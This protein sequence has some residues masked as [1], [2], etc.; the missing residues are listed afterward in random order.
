MNKNKDKYSMKNI[1]ALFYC[2]LIASNISS[3]EKPR[4]LSKEE[5]KTLTTALNG[6]YEDNFFKAKPNEKIEALITLA[7][8]ALA[9]QNA[10]TEL[11]KSIAI[12]GQEKRNK[13]FVHSAIDDFIYNAE[14]VLANR[15]PKRPVIMSQAGQKLPAPAIVKAPAPAKAVP[16]NKQISDAEEKVRVYVKG[17]L[18]SKDLGDFLKIRSDINLETEYMVAESALFDK[19]WIKELTKEIGISE[20]KAKELLQEIKQ[21]IGQLLAERG[22]KNYAVQ[23]KK[24][25]KENIAPWPEYPES[26]R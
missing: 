19:E 22:Y 8:N 15:S 12:T 24:K 17:L 11:S 23:Y 3:M 9:D 21:Q 16:V 1:V 7:H 10:I 2:V 20:I 5:I 4:G 18:K 13:Q 14:T 25:E 26:P 6:R